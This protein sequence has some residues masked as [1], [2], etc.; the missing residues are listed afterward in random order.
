MWVC[1]ILQVGM[2]FWARWAHR[3]LWHA[4]LWHMHEVCFQFFTFI[5][6]Q[7]MLRS[8]DTSRLRHDSDTD[9]ILTRHYIKS[10]DFL[11][12]LLS[13]MLVSVSD[14]CVRAL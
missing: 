7:A 9:T 3:A 5:F 12:L 1:L 4:S 10:C 8:T 14:V 11:E 2:E 6:S 13:S